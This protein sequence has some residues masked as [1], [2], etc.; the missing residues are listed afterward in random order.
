MEA[1]G[2]GARDPHSVGSFIGG[3]MWKV[4]K[5]NGHL[6]QG[7]L[8][9]KHSSEAAALKAAKK[10]IGFKELYFKYYIDGDIHL[11]ENGNQILAETFLANYKD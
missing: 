11:N 3:K 7:D 4:Y 8:V 1:S 2:W 9:S 10:E 5:Y 6:I